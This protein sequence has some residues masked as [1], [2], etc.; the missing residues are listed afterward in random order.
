MTQKELSKINII[1]IEK[2]KLK[3]KRL[4]FF[5]KIYI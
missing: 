3:F 5:F 1:I 4:I 2:K